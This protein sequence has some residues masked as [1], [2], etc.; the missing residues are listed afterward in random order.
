MRKIVRYL[1]K[2][3]NKIRWF[4]FIAYCLFIVYYAVLS[5]G[6]SGD[7]K[8]ELR[9]MW[10]YRE[11]LIGHPEWKEDVG[12][13]L[14]NILFFVPFGFLF[15]PIGI[16]ATAFKNRRWLLI[17]FA[18]ILLSIF[19]ELSQYIFCLGLCELDDVICNGL[20][21]VIGYGLFGRVLL[22]VM[23]Y[24]VLK[25]KMDMKELEQ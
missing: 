17:L 7:H 15:P 13:N 14:K 4:L 18:G 2:N 21:A 12:Y 8:I 5:R 24:S 23:K 25:D 6:P 22:F 3:R 16:L 11:M 1:K 9:F 10:A 19:V 20:G